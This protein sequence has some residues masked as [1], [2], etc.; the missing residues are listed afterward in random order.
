M[1]ISVTPPHYTAAVC[2]R[3]RGSFEKS[4]G[5]VLYFPTADTNQED[6]IWRHI[7]K[8]QQAGLV[9]KSF[10]LWDH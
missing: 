3:S 1:V 6:C 8:F 2:I 5:D 4:Y 10:F 9:E 7:I